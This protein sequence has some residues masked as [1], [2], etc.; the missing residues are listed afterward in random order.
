MLKQLPCAVKD[1]LESL[2]DIITNWVY[3]ED[4]KLITKRV[5]VKREEYLA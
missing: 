1:I 4:G 5:F 3:F 2:V